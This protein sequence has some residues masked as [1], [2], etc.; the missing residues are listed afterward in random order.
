[1]SRAVEVWPEA[2]YGVPPKDMQYRFQWTFPIHISPHD[3]NTV[4]VGSQF[5]HKTSNGGQ[6]WSVISPDLTTNDR[7]KQGN[8]GG[9]VVDNLFVENATVLF[10]IAESPKQAGVIWAGSMDGLLHLTRDGGGHWENV[11]ANI[12]ALPKFANITAIEPSKYDVGTAYIAVDGHQINDRD[13]YIYRTTDYGKSWTRLTSGANGIP[14]SVFSYVHVVREDP[15]RRGLLYAGTENGLY[16]SLDDGGHWHA[17]QNNLPHAPVSWLTIQGHFS[18]LVVSTYGRGFWILDDISPLRALNEGMLQKRA[19]LLPIRPAYRWRRLQSTHQEGS[20]VD[21]EDPVYG[22]N[23]NVWVRKGTS[24]T[25][26]AVR[27]ADS[28]RRRAGGERVPPDSSRLSPSPVA[29]AQ[30]STRRAAAPRTDSILVSILDAQGTL[31]R[32]FS[33]PSRPG[34]NRIYWDLRHQAPRAPRL[35]TAPPGIDFVRVPSGGWRP[36]VPWDL[37]LFGGLLGTLA[38]P[39]TYTAVVVAAGDTMRAPVEVLKDPNSSG[40]LDDIREQVAYSRQLQRQIDSVSDVIDEAEWIRR[41]L[42]DVTTLLGDRKRQARE[43]GAAADSAFAIA[44][45]DSVLAAIRSL[46]KK[47]IDVE[48]K[49]YDVNLTGAREDAF[50]TPNQLYEKL[51]SLASDVGASGADFRPTD[52]HRAVGTL[53]EKQFVEYRT[54]FDRL[55]ADDVAAY[56]RM[57]IARGVPTLSLKLPARPTVQ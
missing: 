30:D 22:A 50:R 37:D 2:G 20:I 31:V 3:H 34:I 24:D 29:G 42:T 10:S 15:V 54:Q 25:A 43:F 19:A 5:V 17:L 6:S 33:A 23:L 39:G 55:L 52:Q 48:G 16:F 14:K 40:T 9:V 35:R 12:P 47:V 51:A 56:N 8:S 27:G 36:L 13:P 49:L 41:Q 32:R 11:T 46:E 28:V 44:Q 38:L 4:Y 18:D 57:A 53:L 21:G 45:V 7:T 26:A 1:M